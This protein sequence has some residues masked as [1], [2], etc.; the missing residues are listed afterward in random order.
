MADSDLLQALRR[1]PAVHQ[2]CY[3]AFVQGPF[4]L[5]DELL[6]APLKALGFAAQ[7]H[8]TIQYTHE[9]V[10]AVVDGEA[11]ASLQAQ[12]VAVLPVVSVVRFLSVD[13]SP[14]ELE[15]MAEQSLVRAR[16]LLGWISGEESTPFAVATATAAGSSFRL[17][18][19]HSRTRRRLGFG[20]VGPAY[21]ALVSA[22]FQAAQ[23]DDR[24]E[25]ALSLLH[26]ALREAN[27]L[28]RIARFFNC[29]E[30][31]ASGLKA[32]HG[33]KSRMAVKELLGLQ[34]GAV[35]ETHIAGEKYRFDPVEI[36][37]RI[38]DKLFHGVQYREDHLN[39]ENR[40]VWRLLET[41]PETI[42]TALQEFCE[43]E[44][45]RWANGASKGLPR[46][47]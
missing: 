7:A 41:Y 15:K 1:R 4:W 21:D 32:K 33:E 24:F 46:D 34:D 43:L 16:R 9:I 31:L 42:A 39:E 23:R 47:A 2:L 25:F 37:G 29:L 35:S 36:G 40:P 20:N 13:A 44:I 45:A 30:C 18:P 8:Y 6:L 26:D 17:L 28:F 14:P 19:P 5:S 12:G 3:G 38:R 27:P 11:V 22:A 10:G